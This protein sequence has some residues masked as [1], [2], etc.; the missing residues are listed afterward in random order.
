[1]FVVRKIFHCAL[2]KNVSSSSPPSRR[3]VT[4][5]GQRLAPMRSKARYAGPL[6]EPS[7]SVIGRNRETPALGARSPSCSRS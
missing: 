7:L 5:P 6:P 1:M 3:L 2:A 4:T